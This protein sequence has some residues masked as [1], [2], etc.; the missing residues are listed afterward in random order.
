MDVIEL[1]KAVN[2]LSVRVIRLEKE[3]NH[4]IELLNLFIGEI[5]RVMLE[6]IQSRK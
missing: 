1:T 2:E 4:E 5:Y 6:T 3:L